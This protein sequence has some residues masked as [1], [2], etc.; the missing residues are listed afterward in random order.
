MAFDGLF[1]S[2]RRTSRPTSRD[3]GLWSELSKMS[4]EVGYPDATR[5]DSG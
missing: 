2:K 5:R 1:A 3:S 4:D